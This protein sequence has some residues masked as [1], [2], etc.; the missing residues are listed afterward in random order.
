M[1]PPFTLFFHPNDSLIF[2]SM[3]SLMSARREAWRPPCRWCKKPLRLECGNPGTVRV[4]RGVRPRS[5]AS[6]EEAGF[7]QES[8]LQLMLCTQN[9]F[10]PASNVASLDIMELN[11]RSGPADAQDFLT[12]RSR[13]FEGRS[14]PQATLPEARRFLLGI[15][16]SGTSHF[17]ARMDGRAVG[18]ASYSLPLRGL[19][20][21]AGIATLQEYRG[22]GIGSAL[23]SLATQE[24]FGK[25]VTMAFLSAADERASRMTTGWGSGI[26]LRRSATSRGDNRAP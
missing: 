5:W 14:A 1:P 2:F 15:A 6:V 9:T 8:R 17:L 16:R 21:V 13:G 4:Y 24:A 19:T 7:E 26:R 12:A 3:G 20:E 22:R 25:G 18:V 23:T 10:S 11:E